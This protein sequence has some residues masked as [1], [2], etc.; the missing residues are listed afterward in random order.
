MLHRLQTFKLKSYKYSDDWLAVRGI[1][2][3]R[4]RGVIA[5]E[6]FEAFPEYIQKVPNY[7]L[8]DQDGNVLFQL[9]YVLTLS[10]L[11]LWMTTFEHD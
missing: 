11:N 7:E 6:V 8:R 3:T 1:R 9:P 5:Q 4:V 10:P 2:Q